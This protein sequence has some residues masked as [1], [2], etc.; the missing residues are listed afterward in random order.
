MPDQH[1]ATIRKNTREEIRVDLTTYGG[2]RLF[3]ARV[4]YQADDG[5]MQPGKSGVAF[6][7]ALLP[8]FAEAVFLALEKARDGGLCE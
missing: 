7:A 1:I 4:W 3:N 8:V 2:H 6:K 5:T